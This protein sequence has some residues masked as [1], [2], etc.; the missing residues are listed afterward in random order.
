MRRP[1]LMRAWKRTRGCSSYRPG[2][3]SCIT[4]YR[5]LRKDF[6][7][8]S[9]IIPR[10]MKPAWRVYHSVA[11]TISFISWLQHWIVIASPTLPERRSK[12]SAQ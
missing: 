3:C 2:E 8:V 10:H 6:S 7:H 12:D 11:A 9:A 1:I 5:F 4:D